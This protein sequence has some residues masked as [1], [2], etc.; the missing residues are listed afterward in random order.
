MRCCPLEIYK[1][2]HGR[3]FFNNSLLRPNDLTLENAKGARSRLVRNDQV[4]GRRVRTQ[5]KG[6]TGQAAML[7][8]EVSGKTPCNLTL[9]PTSSISKI[10]CPFFKSRL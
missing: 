10:Y 8:N 1:A 6:W 2:R 3:S 5:I 9:E 7:A 4:A